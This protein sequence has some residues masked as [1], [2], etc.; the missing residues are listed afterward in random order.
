M[1]SLFEDVPL[2]EFMYP[3]FTRMSGGVTVGDS[4][5]LLCPLSVERCCFP[6]FSLHR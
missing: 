3:A 1:K 6:L 2:V 4:D 5:L